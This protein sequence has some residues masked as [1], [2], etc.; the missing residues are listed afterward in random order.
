MTAEPPT[1]RELP[2]LPDPDIDPPGRTRNLEELKR[3]F[4]AGEID[5]EAYESIVG[6]VLHSLPD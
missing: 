5:L 4:L 3:A 1:E 2:E 6:D